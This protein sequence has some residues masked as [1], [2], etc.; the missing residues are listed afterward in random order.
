MNIH[1]TTTFLVGGVSLTQ[2]TGTDGLNSA[3]AKKVYVDAQID[4]TPLTATNASAIR[5]R[6]G[7]CAAG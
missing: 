5:A 3:D 4:L 6:F 1:A 7:A 2:A